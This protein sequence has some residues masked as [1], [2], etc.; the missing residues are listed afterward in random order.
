MRH[1][2]TQER[3]AWALKKHER[4]QWLAHMNE[5]SRE[6]GP[7]GGSKGGNA[8]A[9]KRRKVSLPTFNLPELVE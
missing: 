8:T 4:K 1:Y 3:E 7:R 6:K 9:S 2:T 5:A